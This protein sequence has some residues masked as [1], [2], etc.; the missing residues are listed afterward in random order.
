MQLAIS[1]RTL[2]LFAM[3]LPGER[4]AKTNSA[5]LMERV[6]LA[7]PFGVLEYHIPYLY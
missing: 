6:G 7:L 1:D 2:H 4:T 5:I 3:D